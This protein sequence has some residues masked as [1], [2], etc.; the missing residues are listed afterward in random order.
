MPP[1]ERVKQRVEINGQQIGDRI[2]VYWQMPAR[3]AGSGSTLRISRVDIYRLAEK[4]DDPL[5]LTEEEFSDRATLIGSLTIQDSDF[6]LSKKVFSDKLK[7]AGQAARLRYAVR[8]ANEAGQKAAFSNFF[9]IEP[10]ANVAISPSDVEASVSQTAVSIAWSA[11]ALNLDGTSPAN[12][13][14][15]NIYRALASGPAVLLNKK[16]VTSTK[17]DDETFEFGKTFLYF[18][19]AVS[20]GRNAESVESFSSETIAISPVDTFKPAPPEAVTIAAAPSEVSIFF[21]FNLEKDIAGYR[22]FRSTDP[23]IPKADWQPLT[24]DLLDVNT[25]QDQTVVRG[26]VYYYFVVAIDTA[27]NVS[28]P[29]EVVSD[30]A[31]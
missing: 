30:T 7:I 14:G 31:L 5:S 15:Y 22:V 11:P 8:F 12:L 25:F 13:I 4:L 9:V 28:E 17:F 24:Q 19:R 27:G 26:V 6:G 16:P 21:A 2:D 20:L 1:I 29:S 23:S 10:A 18:V 3:N